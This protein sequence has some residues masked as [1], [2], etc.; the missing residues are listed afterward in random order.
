MAAPVNTHGETKNLEGGL[1]SQGN[2]FEP[3]VN[4]LVFVDGHYPRALNFNSSGLINFTDLKGNVIT[5]YY[6]SAGV[7]SIRCKVFTSFG[8]GVTAGHAIF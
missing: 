4:G 7:N 2:T 5:N 6:V 8:T 3:L 1:E